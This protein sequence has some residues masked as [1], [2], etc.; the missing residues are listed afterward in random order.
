MMPDLANRLLAGVS[1]AQVSAPAGAA[2][3]RF[4][5]SLFPRSRWERDL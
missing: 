3:E 5:S 1:A 4:E 2:A